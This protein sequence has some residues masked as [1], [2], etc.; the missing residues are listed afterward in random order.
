MV[1][2]GTFRDGRGEF[3]RWSF[4]LKFVSSVQR[5]RANWGR[6]S[7]ERFQ[8]RVPTK[9]FERNKE[10]SKNTSSIHFW[11]LIV[12]PAPSLTLFRIES[13][14]P[15]SSNGEIN[16]LVR[17]IAKPRTTR[18]VRLFSKKPS[19]TESTTESGVSHLPSRSEFRGKKEIEEVERERVGRKKSASGAAIRH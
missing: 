17:R 14:V 16:T 15:G 3:V 13:K 4:Q 12:H 5:N 10:A 2:A 19:F 6:W 11:S 18:I 1:P 8:R 7:I 9:K